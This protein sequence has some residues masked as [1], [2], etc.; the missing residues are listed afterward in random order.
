ME[1]PHFKTLTVDIGG[2]HIRGAILN[3]N[4]EALEV[5]HA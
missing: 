4:G 1:K 5:Y 2:S 3:Q